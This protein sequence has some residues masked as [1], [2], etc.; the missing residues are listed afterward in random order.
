MLTA[1]D[2]VI[3]SAQ[4]GDDAFEQ[5]QFEALEVDFE[6]VLQE[7]GADPQLE[8]FRLEYETLYRALK[9]SHESE[10]RLVKKCKELTSDVA[11][12]V[13]KTTASVKLSA[14]DQQQIISLKQEI[15]R[16]STAV[17]SSL[18]KEKETKEELATLRE[19]I[20]GLRVEVKQGASGSVQQE[21]KLRDLTGQRDDLM[22][23]R[24]STAHQVMNVRNDIA[25]LGDRL[26]VVEAEKAQVRAAATSANGV[27]V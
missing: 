16:T 11:T 6:N 27:H 1:T 25:D 3:P 22:R 8:R 26:K 23:E 5:S 18:L 14:D 21:A 12:T 7:L 19:D 13:Q 24:D 20:E 17:E 9:K 10:K 15:L 4:D 2:V